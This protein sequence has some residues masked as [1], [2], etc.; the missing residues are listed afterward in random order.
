MRKIFLTLVLV[1]FSLGANALE[2]TEGFTYGKHFWQNTFSVSHD[3]N[4]LLN[5]GINFDLTEHEDIDNHIYTFSLPIMLRT[6]NTGLLFRPFITPDNANNA[7]AKGA[8][9][10]WTFTFKQDEINQSFAHLFLSA[11]FAD[12]N[13]YIIK[14]GQLPK[15]DNFYQLAYDGGL[16]FDCFD[17]YFFEVSGNMFQYLSGINSVEGVAGVLDQQNI[18]YL[19]TL[20]YVIGLPKGSAEAKIRWKSTESKSDNSISY[21]FIE[22][23]DKGRTA[24]HSLKITSK[25]N[26]GDKVFVSLA[27]NHIFII[28]HTDKDIFKGAISYQF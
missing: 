5:A 11:G 10:S 9:L 17:V 27:Y 18:A 6:E 26:M 15:K 2:L 23:Y 25:I 16:V 24:E 19:G 20:D 3:F 7:S 28:G 22:Y 14:E 13:A 1:C 4:Y 12:Q 21:R 8:K